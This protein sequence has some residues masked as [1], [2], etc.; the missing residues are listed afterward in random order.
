MPI[1]YDR[2]AFPVAAAIMCE[3]SS[4]GLVNHHFFEMCKYM[5][6]SRLFSLFLCVVLATS[7]VWNKAIYNSAAARHRTL[8]ILLP[9]SFFATSLI[10]EGRY[11]LQTRFRRDISIDGWDITT[12]GFW[13]QTSAM[14]ELYFR[15]RFLRL[16]HYRHVILHLPTK[17]RPNRTV[18]DIVITLS[19]GTLDT[20]L[21]NVNIYFSWT[22]TPPWGCLQ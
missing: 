2:R 8:D 1:L 10:W 12:S 16:R 18:R 11:L 14:V 3:T 19:Y 22:F 17:F 6:A 20:C 13:K 15:F 21:S 5:S 7:W 4:A 9:D